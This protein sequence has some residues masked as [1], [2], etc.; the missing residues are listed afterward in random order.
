MENLQLQAAWWPCTYVIAAPLG[1][2]CLGPGPCTPPL[3]DL[4]RRG[5]QQPPRRPLLVQEAEQGGDDPLS[6]RNLK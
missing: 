6:R 1:G 2:G 4:I 5:K 3:G